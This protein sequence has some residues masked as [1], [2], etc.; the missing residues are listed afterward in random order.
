MRHGRVPVGPDH[1]AL[2]VPHLGHDVRAM[3]T[4]SL[5]IPAA[6]M[7]IWS[8]VAVTSFWPMAVWARTGKFSSKS[9]VKMERA[10]SGRS[11]GA[12]S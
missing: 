11:I 10:G 3:T 12:P 6:A 1:V 7:A 5:A 4:P 9:V 8:G 2:V